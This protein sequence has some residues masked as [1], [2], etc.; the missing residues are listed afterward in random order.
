MDLPATVFILARIREGGPADEGMALYAVNGP[1]RPRTPVFSSIRTASE[2]LTRAQQLGHAVRFDY[3]FRADGARL[4][5]DFPE[6]EA[7]L[8]PV[9]DELFGAAPA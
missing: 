9:A 4:D 3:L 5:S 1:G 2:F 6:Y 7:V 8:D